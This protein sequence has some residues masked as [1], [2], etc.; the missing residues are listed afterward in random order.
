MASIIGA[1]PNHPVIQE[2]LRHYDSFKLSSNGS[3][4][5]PILDGIMAKIL[6][7]YGLRYI[8]GFQELDNSIKIYP[9]SQFLSGKINKGHLLYPSL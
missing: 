6:Y 5:N 2:L 8:D 1:E 3:F 4:D 7:R 9:T